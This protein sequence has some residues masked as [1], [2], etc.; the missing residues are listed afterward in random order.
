MRM[1]RSVFPFQGEQLR[2]VLLLALGMG[3]LVVGLTTLGFPRDATAS[4]SDY[5]RGSLTQITDSGGR[6][7][8][9]H[10]GAAIYFDRLDTDGFW[11]VWRM[12]P[13][14][15]G[16]QCLTCDDPRLPNKHQG[17]P[18][19]H[20]LGR[21]LVFQAEKAEHTGLGAGTRPGA[22]RYNDLWV[23]DLETNDVYQLTDV[24]PDSVSGSLHAQF[25]SDGTKLLWA[26][27]EGP[28]PRRDPKCLWDDT[29]L[30]V[31]DFVA[32]P[33]PHLEN[34]AYYDPGLDS[35]FKESHGWGPDDSWIYF[36][37][38]A[39][40]GMS[41][42]AM[43]ICR[44]DFSTPT[45]V[46]RLTLTSGTDGEEE[47]WD[48]HAHL[49][50]LNDAFVWTSSQPYGTPT[51]ASKIEAELQTDLWIMNVDGSGQQRVTFFNDSGHPDH[52]G[53]RAVVGD[54]DWSPDGTR[55]LI[56]V[57]FPDSGARHRIYVL[58]LAHGIATPTPT[59]TATPEATATPTPT[60]TST[61]E[62][63]A[64]PTPTPTSTPEATAT[65]TPT[66]TAE[67]SGTGTIKGTVTDAN[68]GAKLRDVAVTTDTGQS[69]T[70]NGA[71]KYT[72]QGVPEGARTVT[73]SQNGYIAQSKSLTM[74]ADRT[75][76]VDFAL[77]P[78]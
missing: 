67:P 37:C 39:V 69:A 24:N 78:E 71:G 3:V 68:T 48:E 38:I 72:L 27:I 77:V 22:G 4:S 42:A 1:R 54:N 62:A 13:D 25:N 73:A 31:A 59:P 53:D 23:L 21:Y 7:D 36:T 56:Y 75:E 16:Q 8:W 76:T 51:K 18:E 43:D 55:L 20:P 9:A 52:T 63:T 12:N 46:T 49:S 41:D 34:T 74:I 5:V 47:E 6:V 58:D 33:W 44:M 30:A 32:E 14:G 35:R 64:T 70:T 15:T 65:P 2:T 60:P 26:S 28:A 10:D 19:M 50:P 11:D 29:R 45:E 61:P 40:E 66:P 17:N 57:Q